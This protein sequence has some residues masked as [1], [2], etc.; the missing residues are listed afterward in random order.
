MRAYVRIR[1]PRGRC[2]DLCPG[3]LVGRGWR[4]ELRLDDPRVSEA[5]AMVS[6]RGSHM[7]MLALRGPLG[8]RRTPTREATLLPGTVVRLA[9]DLALTVEDV[10][11]PEHIVALTGVHDGP[12]VL[13]RSVYSLVRHGD[14]TIVEASYRPDA[15]AWLW[16]TGAGWQVRIG[17]DEDARAVGPGDA[18]VVGG[19]PIE[20]GVEG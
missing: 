19:V 2:F 20:S 6:L 4:C 14:R 8:V 17:K 16:S 13:Q 12:V 3:D 7:K 18:L 11:V 10:V 9:R 15:A 5:H 1:D